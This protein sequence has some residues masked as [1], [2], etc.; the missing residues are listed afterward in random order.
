MS[1]CYP[2]YQVKYQKFSYSGK[3]LIIVWRVSQVISLLVYFID[4]WLVIGVAHQIYMLV[5]LFNFLMGDHM[6]VIFLTCRYVDDGRPF[7]QYIVSY[8]TGCS[9]DQYFEELYYYY[10]TEKVN[11]WHWYVFSLYYISILNSSPLVTDVL[12]YF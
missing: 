4:Y 3:F 1:I 5:N 11:K 10:M 8:S 6:W 12:H 9:N 2:K 7:W